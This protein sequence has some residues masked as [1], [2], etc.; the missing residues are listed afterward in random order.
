MGK[1]ISVTMMACEEDGRKAKEEEQFAAL[2]EELSPTTKTELM[3]NMKETGDIE[4]NRTLSFW[5][6]LRYFQSVLKMLV[7]D[8]KIIMYDDGVICSSK[9]IHD[10]FESQVNVKMFVY[11]LFA[12]IRKL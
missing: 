2:I 3:I 6:I 11:L 8:Q 7:N 9:W 10:H 4:V 12:P 5:M 1:L